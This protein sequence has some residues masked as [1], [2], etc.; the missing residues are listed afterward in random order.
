MQIVACHRP[1]V[2]IEAAPYRI[3]QLFNRKVIGKKVKKTVEFLLVVVPK[4]LSAG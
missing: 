3:A 4:T 1:V 2:G